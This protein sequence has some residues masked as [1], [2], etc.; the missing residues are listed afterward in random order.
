MAA[1]VIWLLHNQIQ[2]STGYSKRQLS[3]FI[4]TDSCTDESMFRESLLIEGNAGCGGAV[5]MHTF[6]EWSRIYWS[7]IQTHGK[8]GIFPHVKAQPVTP[9]VDE[10]LFGKVETHPEIAHAADWTLSLKQQN[11]T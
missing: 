2:A 9:L 1:T 5:A 4:F 10:D 7:W 8:S 6:L 3:L 11:Q